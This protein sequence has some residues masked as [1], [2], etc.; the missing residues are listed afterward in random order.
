MCRPR[1]APT[2]GSRGLFPAQQFA[3]AR[4]AP[5][6]AGQVAIAAHHAVAGHGHRQRIACACACD[7]TA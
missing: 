5:G 6:I 1:S 4:Y 7:G 3:L 2:S